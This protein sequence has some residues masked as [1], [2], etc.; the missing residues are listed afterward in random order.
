MLSAPF[1]FAIG[2][3]GRVLQLTFQFLFPGK[4]GA[5]GHVWQITDGMFDITFFFR[6]A[7][8]DNLPASSSHGPFS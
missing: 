5:L 4:N 8:F 7:I 1:P 6:E 3:H 2:R